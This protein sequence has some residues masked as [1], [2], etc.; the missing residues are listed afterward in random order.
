[1]IN[2]SLLHFA[3]NKTTTTAEEFF[4]LQNYLA[5]TTHFH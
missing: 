2:N 1:M 5:R 3:T 4:T